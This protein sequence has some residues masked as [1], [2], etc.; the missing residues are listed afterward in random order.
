MFDVGAEVSY[1]EG[2]GKMLR[3]R[4]AMLIRHNLHFRN[5]FM[6]MASILMLTRLHILWE[7]P[8][9]F[10]IQLPDNVAER[11]PEDSRQFTEIMWNLNDDHP[12]DFLIKGFSDQ[13]KCS[14][15][16]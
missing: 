1:P 5:K 11:I 14:E 6:L 7:T 13:I 4:D 9:R 12:N 10:T 3:F 15:R 16:A 8:P 2:K